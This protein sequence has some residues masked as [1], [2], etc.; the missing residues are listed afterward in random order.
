MMR[1]LGPHQAIRLERIRS[2]LDDKLEH[3]GQ[4]LSEGEVHVSDQT[5]LV[6]EE[7]A[8]MEPKRT[9]LRCLTLHPMHQSQ[10]KA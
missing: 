6:D 1:L 9:S 3:L 7:F 10:D 8:S 2:E 5:A 4:S